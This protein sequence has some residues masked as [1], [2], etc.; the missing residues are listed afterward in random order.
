MRVDEKTECWE[1]VSESESST[2]AL[3]EALGRML[4]PGDVVGLVGELGAGKTA[5]VR[6]IARGAGVPEG[7]PVNSPTFTIMNL[8]DAPGVGLCHLDLYRL[9][10]MDEWEGVGVPELL[11]GGRAL[12]VEWADRFP[13]SL[14][15]ETLWVEFLLGS[16]DQRVIRCRASGEEA[17]ELLDQWKEAFCAGQVR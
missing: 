11:T 4:Q 7:C 3:G 8:Y 1:V 15:H 14:P 12:L 2:E 13:D 16:G 9:S 6:G 10:T 17:Q 5:L